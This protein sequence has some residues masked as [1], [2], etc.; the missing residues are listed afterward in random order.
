MITQSPLRKKITDY[1]HIDETTC[2]NELLEKADQALY[3]AKNSGRN[4]TIIYKEE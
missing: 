2:I 3:K 1:Y 4:S